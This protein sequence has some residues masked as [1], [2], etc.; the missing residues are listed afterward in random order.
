MI[1][2]SIE[3]EYCLFGTR[4]LNESLNRNL[5][6]QN[7]RLPIVEHTALFP[8]TRPLARDYDPGQTPSGR[9]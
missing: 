3:S 2:W 5:V 8:F 9:L 4:G 1:L 6:Y 7:R